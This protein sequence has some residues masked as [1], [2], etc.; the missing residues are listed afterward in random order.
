MGT[1]PDAIKRLVD[2]SA[3][4]AQA[5]RFDRDRRILPVADA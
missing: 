2:L 5:G 1:A 4:N 3:C